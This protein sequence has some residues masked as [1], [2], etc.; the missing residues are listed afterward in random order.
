MIGR[1]HGALDV[2]QV[3]GVAHVGDE[4]GAHLAHGRDCPGE[5]LLP[6]LEDRVLVIP[7]VE[8]DRPVIGVHDGLDGVAHVVGLLRRPQE[9]ALVVG[10]RRRLGQ[11]LVLGVG[12]VVRRGVTVD[13]PHHP[14]GSGRVVIVIDNGRVGTV[15][16][17]Q[18]GGH[19]GD[20]LGRVPVVEDL[21]SLAHLLGEED[22]GLPELGGVEQAVERVGHARPAVAGEGGVDLTGLGLVVGVVQL[23]RRAVVLAAHDGVGRRGLTEVDPG[24][25]LAQVPLGRDAAL[26]EGGVAAGG[27]GVAVGVHDAVAMGVH[28]VLVDPGPLSLAEAGQVQLAHRDDRV[29]AAGAHLVA[30]DVETVGEGVVLLVLLELLEGR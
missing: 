28:R 24:L 25:V 8:L 2:E 18:P 5:D 22:V 20:A 15:I 26:P 29:P 3:L 14:L 21:G 11:G 23:A 6:G 7:L 19:L 30:V 9:S 4:V 27:H 16:Q 10:G 12:V 17:G 13:D 1:H